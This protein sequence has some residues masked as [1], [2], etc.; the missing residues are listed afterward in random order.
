MM[1]HPAAPQH[2]FLYDPP[3]GIETIVK[4]LPHRYPFLMVDGITAMGQDWIT[5]FKNLTINE[6]CFQG[7][8]PGTPVFPGVLQVET[9][10]QVGAVWILSLE[11]NRGKIAYLMSMEEVKFR[12]PAVPGMRLDCHGRI[13]NLRS[14]TGRLVAEMKC[15]DTLISSAV[16]FFAFQKDQ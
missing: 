4:I 3:F 6:A 16:L 15:G 7:H 14:R 5:G 8:F 10:A 1:E 11:Q 9:M 2:K 13:T 12:K